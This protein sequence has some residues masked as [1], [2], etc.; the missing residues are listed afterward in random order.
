[1][2]QEPQDAE[3]RRH[4]RRLTPRVLRRAAVLVALIA[5]CATGLG[6]YLNAR[7]TQQ[8]TIVVGSQHAA[9]RI[10]VIATI[11]NV[12]TTAGVMTMR[13]E[14]DPQGKYSDD[15]GTNSPSTALTLETTSQRQGTI[16]LPAHQRILTLSVPISLDDG[17]EADY[18]FDRYSAV[19]GVGVAA[20]G[21][22]VPVSL[23]VR[24]T[25]ALFSPKNQG[26]LASPGDAVYLDLRVGR[27][28]GTFILAWFMIA[29]NWALSLSVLAAALVIGGLRRGLV[30]PALGWMAA[31]MFAMVSLR[32]AAP[33]SPPIGSLLDYV[34]FF[35]AEA[36]TAVALVYVVVCGVRVESAA[37]REA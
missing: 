36:I 3:A 17:D 35:W 30:Y 15:D 28:R 11:Q 7:S 12:D 37:A 23:T 10:D 31:T 26:S 2:A 20:A 22:I 9:D 1:M 6:L 21:T 29:M 33:G 4:S 19:V 32:N 24:N 13:L 27:S 5:V 25:D 16:T 34:S 8:R 18:P 14:V